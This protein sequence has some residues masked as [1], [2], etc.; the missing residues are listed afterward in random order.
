M[1][2]NIVGRHKESGKDDSSLG[3]WTYICIAGKGDRKFY[4]ITGYRPCIQSN[5]GLGTVK[6]QQQHLLT[7][8]GNPDS[9]VKKEWD[10]DILNL[11]KQWKITR[12]KLY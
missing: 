8:K 2:D 12:Q 9:K 7:M 11:I 6:A 1:T 5:P 4:V 3:R 10:K